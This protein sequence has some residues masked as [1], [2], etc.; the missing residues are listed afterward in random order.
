M[1][2]I[3]WPQKLQ[4]FQSDGL[5][6]IIIIIIFL[7]VFCFFVFCFC[8]VLWWWWV[9]ASLFNV[10]SFLFLFICVV[11]WLSDRAFPACEPS[12]YSLGWE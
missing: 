4:F 12:F 2:E 5:Y 9:G 8:V 1:E 3:L 7:C 6:F 10:P 11:E